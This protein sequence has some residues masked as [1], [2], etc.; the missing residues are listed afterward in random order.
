MTGYIS[1]VRHRCSGGS[2]INQPPSSFVVSGGIEIGGGGIVVVV[3][4]LVMD[5]VVAVVAVLTAIC[6]GINQK[7]R[8]SIP[9]GGWEQ[10]GRI[11]DSCVEGGGVSGGLYSPR[12]DGTKISLMLSVG[13]VAET[14]FELPYTVW[15]NST[16]F[17]GENKRKMEIRIEKKFILI[18]FTL[19][20]I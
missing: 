15:T 18:Y 10:K 12:L 17:P 11:N 14:I 13:H 20:I 16:H 1:T 5:T 6:L 7:R 8:L 2:E 9:Q 19:S 3:L 4:V